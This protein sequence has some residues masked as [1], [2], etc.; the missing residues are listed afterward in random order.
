M[1]ETNPKRLY[2]ILEAKQKEM[3]LKKINVL[4]S[5]CWY[6]FMYFAVFLQ[7][8]FRFSGTLNRFLVFWTVFKCFG[9][10]LALI[11]NFWRGVCIYK[12][13]LLSFDWS[14]K[15]RKETPKV[16]SFFSFF[17]SSF[18]FL[19]CFYMSIFGF[20]TLCVEECRRILCVLL[21]R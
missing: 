21:S 11:E 3:W 20:L 9:G 16:S 5:Q 18:C 14:K 4:T 1:L 8:Q 15:K 12:K 7:D 2:H 19:S 17:F 10:K 13:A 6:V